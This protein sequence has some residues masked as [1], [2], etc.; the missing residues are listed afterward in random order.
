MHNLLLVR[1]SDSLQE[2]LTDLPCGFFIK[3]PL[4]NDALVQTAPVAS[5]GNQVVIIGSFKGIVELH[6][7]VVFQLFQNI[8][9]VHQCLFVFFF[10]MILID[11][12]NGHLLTALSMSALF[13]FAKGALAQSRANLV[14]L[15]AA[16]STGRVFRMFCQVL[17]LLF[18]PYEDGLKWVLHLPCLTNLL[19][20]IIGG[21]LIL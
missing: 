21:L 13:D 6:D 8:N 11:H 15:F 12:F 18:S 1:I 10:Q 9:F 7:T 2:R 4:G 14:K 20:G 5:L 19:G 3:L 17:A 16:F